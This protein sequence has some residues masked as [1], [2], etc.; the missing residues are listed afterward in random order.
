MANAITASS[1]E[2]I[3][4][5]IDHIEDYFYNKWFKD[6]ELHALLDYLY[7]ADYN[8][9]KYLIR[10]DGLLIDPFGRKDDEDEAGLT[11]L[12][13]AYKLTGNDFVD[14]DKESFDIDGKTYKVEHKVFFHDFSKIKPLP[15]KFSVEPEP[16]S[17]SDDIRRGIRSC[18]ISI[19]GDTDSLYLSFKPMMEYSNYTGDELKFVLLFNGLF[20]KQ[21]FKGFLD[22]Y[23][24]IYHVKNIHDFEL[25]TI[26]RSGLHVEKKN[27]I[28]NVVWEDGVHHEPLTYFI[29][30]GVEIV[31]SST[32]L[33]VRENIW[34]FL[35]YIF[36]N[37]GHLDIKEILKMIKDVKK[38]FMLADVEDISMTTSCSKYDEKVIDDQ[39]EMN[40]VK[41]AN[42]S[43]KAAAFHNYLLNKNSEYKTKYDLIRGGKVKYYYCKS[44][45]K[46]DVFAYLRNFH[47]TEIVTKEK[48]NI[49][50]DLQF[51]KTF[52]KICN[53]FLNPIGLPTINKRLSILTSLFSFDKKKEKKK[54]IVEEEIEEQIQDKEEDD[55]FDSFWE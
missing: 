55:I 42:F 28:N 48:I 40:V 33:F 14:N 51:D 15:V 27:Y 12:L 20:V 46:Q 19:Y 16:N 10:K 29:S 1:R 41:G 39:A 2:V 43:V 52:L 21:L 5:M 54:K 22:E 35:K 11:K 37:A 23:A 6:K 49:D 24:A 44:D 4:F 8:N 36:S 50:Y 30:K 9:E 45:Y 47:P 7:I 13:N 32:P 26:N 3:N 31:K 17:K 53:R 34:G 18:P 38:Q 25:E